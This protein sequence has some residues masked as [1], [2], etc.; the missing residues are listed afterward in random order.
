MLLTNPDLAILEDEGAKI[1][2]ELLEEEVVETVEE[3]TAKSRL[4][5]RI[6][7]SLAGGR[8][9]AT[10]AMVSGL[11]EKDNRVSVR[12]C[13]WLCFGYV[14]KFFMLI[15]EMAFVFHKSKQA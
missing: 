4:Y 5:T 10:G 3:E 2:F 15:R 11:K 1:A 12:K 8:P 7:S 14:I 6:G 13:I 9:N